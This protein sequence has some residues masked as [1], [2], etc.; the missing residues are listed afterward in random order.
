MGSVSSFHLPDGYTLALPEDIFRNVELGY[1]SIGDRKRTSIPA[2]SL[3]RQDLFETPVPSRSRLKMKEGHGLVDKMFTLHQHQSSISSVSA[4]SM[5]CQ[6]Q[7]P[8][9]E[10]Y[11]SMCTAYDTEDVLDRRKEAA[12]G[13]SI[14]AVYD[15]HGGHEVAKFLAENAPAY[16][17][18]ELKRNKMLEGTHNLLRAQRVLTETILGLDAEIISRMDSGAAIV[19]VILY[20]RGKDGSR[21]MD[22]LHVGDSRIYVMKGDGSNDV[23]RLT[24]DHNLDDEAERRIVIEN[25]GPYDRLKKRVGILGINMT[26][27][28][29][30]R[31]DKARKIPPINRSIRAIPTV[32]QATLK[33]N[34]RVFL[35]SD[36]VY[37]QA[38][39]LV[40]IEP[41]ADALTSLLQNTIKIA[42]ESDRAHL[43]RI[44]DSALQVSTDNITG[45]IVRNQAVETDNHELKIMWGPLLDPTCIDSV[46]C[47]TSMTKELNMEN[48]FIPYESILGLLM[49]S[50][51]TRCVDMEIPC[52]NRL[53]FT[54]WSTTP[55]PCL[56]VD[57]HRKISTELNPVVP[58]VIVE[59]DQESMM[60]E[61]DAVMLDKV[62]N[63]E[64]PYED[65][66]MVKIEKAKY[67]RSTL[68]TCLSQLAYQVGN[69]EMG[70]WLMLQL[71]THPSTSNATNIDI[72]SYINY[73]YHKNLASLA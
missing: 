61:E 15:G 13:G 37:E 57:Q 53:L 50:R 33:D 36:G 64:M 73:C 27:C 43:T 14:F 19:I 41:C 58:Y 71:E 56:T 10:D 70:L 35:C 47:T 69:A 17:F 4:V 5:R 38:E 51:E 26:R 52:D 30:D 1:V 67:V 12:W 16:I 2:G 20:P 63:S 68:G 54:V 45:M 46:R 44:I 39:L 22:Y 34:D 11:S 28:M 49:Q 18:R 8:Y 62:W 60:D 42:D 23:T 40:G 72:E 24:L 59:S 55:L 31:R 25:G 3:I 29:G 6:G 21:T 48:I 66:E 32:G 65:G 9:M 7:R